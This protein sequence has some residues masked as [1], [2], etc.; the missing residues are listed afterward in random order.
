MKLNHSDSTKKT[1]K[2]RLNDYVKWHKEKHSIEGWVYFVGSE[3]ITIEISVTPKPEEDIPNG[4][5][6]RNN[7]CLVVCYPQ[8]YHE[9]EYVTHREHVH[10]EPT[11]YKSQ[12]YRDRDL[13]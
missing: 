8:F 3:Y 10:A 6:H 9:L 11:T 1:Y 5:P 4:T 12:T 7:R 2:P 13:Y